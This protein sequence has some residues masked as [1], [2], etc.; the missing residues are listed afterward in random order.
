MFI[1]KVVVYISIFFW[2]L[3]PIRQFRQRYFYY[4]L[5]LALADPLALVCANFLHCSPH[6]IHPI[7]GFIL[8]YTIDYSLDRLKN[9]WILHSLFLIGFIIGLIFIENLLY[10]VLLLHLIIALKF[11]YITITEA[12]NENI[13]N[14][15]H[16]ALI[17]YELSVV[18]NLSV[19]LSGSEIKVI[20]YYMTLF[21]Q[22]LLA[23]FFCIFTEKSKFLLKKLKTTD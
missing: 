23:L 2:L 14:I 21:F 20:I 10:L 11:I 18:I 12:Y 9:N 19:Y 16:L 15:F 8:V 17:F 22:I 5:V 7:S 1:A 3:P 6:L 4:F 13:L